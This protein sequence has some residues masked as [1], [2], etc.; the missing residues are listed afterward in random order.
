LIL[1]IELRVRLAKSRSIMAVGMGSVAL[2]TRMKQPFSLSPY[3]F[4]A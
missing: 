1:P 3:F 2:P 4:L